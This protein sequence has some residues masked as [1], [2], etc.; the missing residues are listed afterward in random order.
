MLVVVEGSTQLQGGIQTCFAET[1][2]LIE[3]VQLLEPCKL[4]ITHG[5]PT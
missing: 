4:V 1:L 2:L 5:T 3:T